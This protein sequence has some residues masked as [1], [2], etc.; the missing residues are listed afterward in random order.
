MHIVT[1]T[2][3]MFWKQHT[4]THTLHI[5]YWGLMLQTDLF[6][7][8]SFF[9]DFCALRPHGLPQKAPF[10]LSPTLFLFRIQSLIGGRHAVKSFP[11][12]CRI[13]IQM[14]DQGQE[15]DCAW[16]PCVL[17][18]FPVSKRHLGSSK[19]EHME[20]ASEPTWKMQTD[21]ANKW[22]LQTLIMLI[23]HCVEYLCNAMANE[24]LL[25]NE[26]YN[27]IMDRDKKSFDDSHR[28]QHFIFPWW[29]LTQMA[30]LRFI[31]AESVYCFPFS[32]STWS[33]YH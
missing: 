10:V 6:Q 7:M 20:T 3:Y 26:E 28:H 5:Y 12:A 19:Q 16:G 15:S 24:D 30:G 29:L 18:Q 8:L 23:K 32:L 31:V 17:H 14:R 27:M 9:H 25:V 33:Y 4:I 21:K 22:Q 1:P 2:V 11:H 13:F